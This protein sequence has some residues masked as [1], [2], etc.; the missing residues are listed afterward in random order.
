[1]QTARTFHVLTLRLFQ[2]TVS[3]L[4]MPGLAQTNWVCSPPKMRHAPVACASSVTA[5]EAYQRLVHRPF[6]TQA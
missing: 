1:M 4:D 5:R 6:P 3:M 2:N